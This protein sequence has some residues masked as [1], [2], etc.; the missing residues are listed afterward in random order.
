MMDIK[1][2]IKADKIMPLMCWD[3]HILELSKNKQIQSVQEDIEELKQLHS[4]NQWLTDIDFVQHASFDALV[5]TNEHQ[6]IDWVSS[7]FKG[8]TGYEATEVIGQTARKL[9]GPETTLISRMAIQD[10]LKTRQPFKHDI[11]NYRKNGEAYTCRLEIYPLVNEQEEI[12]HFLAL[13][14]EIIK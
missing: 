11:I 5:V 8:M 3:V 13:E 12:T 9:Q 6:V 2:T 14:H 4:V 7:G 10:Q 1:G